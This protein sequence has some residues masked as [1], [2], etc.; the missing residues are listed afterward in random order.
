MVNIVDCDQEYTW[1]KFYMINNE[2]LFLYSN[3]L[4]KNMIIDIFLLLK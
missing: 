4:K 2:I 1:Y 3:Q